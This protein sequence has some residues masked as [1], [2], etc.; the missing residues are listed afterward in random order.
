M[1]WLVE[2]FQLLKEQ[3]RLLWVVWDLFLAV[4]LLVVGIVTD[5]T[6]LAVFCT[7]FLLM[8]CWE[9]EEVRIV[10]EL[11]ECKAKLSDA[12]DDLCLKRHEIKRLEMELGTMQAALLDAKRTRPTSKRKPRQTE[13]KNEKT[14]D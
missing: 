7:F 11:N 2:T 3:K 8:V 4:A 5:N 6:P 1:K 9:M 12:E 10:K 13:P 14:V